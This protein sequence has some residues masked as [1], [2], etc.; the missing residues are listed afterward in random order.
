[1]AI[2]RNLD[3]EKNW[4]DLLEAGRGAL[5]R[6][7]TAR[8]HIGGSGSIRTLTIEDFEQLNQVSG[9]HERCLYVITFNL[10]QVSRFFEFL[11]EFDCSLVLVLEALRAVPMSERFGFFGGRLSGFDV[12]LTKIRTKND[13][14]PMAIGGSRSPTKRAVV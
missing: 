6:S 14:T 9:K 1:M 12:T 13:P 8:V 3:N 10:I 11:R 4:A 5:V 2:L 7:P